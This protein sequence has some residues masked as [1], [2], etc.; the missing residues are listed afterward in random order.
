[1]SLTKG[2]LKLS[3]FY[4][5]I[6]N[7]FSGIYFDKENFQKAK[8]SNHFYTEC[9]FANLH[10]AE[11]FLRSNSSSEMKK[12]YSVKNGRING[13][14]LSWEDCKNVTNGYTGAKYKGFT[15]LDAAI[16][17]F[18]SIPS[19]SN[20]NNTI[21]TKAKD[22]NPYAYVDGSFNSITKTYGYGVILFANGNSYEFSD[23][24]NDI[25][26]VSMRNVAGEINGAMR[27]VKEAI[28]MSLPEITLYYDYEGI[29]K[30]V[31]GE[32][33]CNKTG[34]KNYAEYMNNAKKS[35]K[36]NFVKVKAHTG[37]E[38]NEKVDM[39]AKQAVGLMR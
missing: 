16:E 33:R 38:L 20:K 27:A 9:S 25:E 4:V 15:Q 5:L 7:Q 12:F 18:T 21:T 32:W 36:I 23:S 31:T 35:I 28:K 19:S 6:S 1:M 13:I 30:W 11:A 37:V 39:L 10:E 2:G 3:E 34:T 26:L 22:E 24:D 17:Y 14:M 29:M 8:S